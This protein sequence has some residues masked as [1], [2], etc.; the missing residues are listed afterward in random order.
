MWVFRPSS[1]TLVVC[2]IAVVTTVEWRRGTF[3]SGSFDP[4]VVIK[5][6][7]SLVGLAIA[8]STPRPPGPRTRLGT[9]SLWFLGLYLLCTVFGALTYGSLLAG[10][11]V[12]F[13]VAVLAATVFFLLRSVP[14]ERVLAGLVWA[15]GLLV[16]VAALLGFRTAAG[17]RLEG[18]VPP[19]H[20]NE[21]ALLSGLVVLVVA[22]RL[23]LGET[24]WLGG[25][26]VV[27]FLGLMW[28][29]G[30]RTGLIMLL[31][32]LAVM[33]LH[34]RRPAVGLVVGFFAAAAVGL[35]VVSR[36]SLVGSF[37]ARDGTGDSTLQSRFIA[38]SAARLWADSFW[39]GAFGG[40]L[41]IKE[42][43]VK[44][45]WWNK[46]VLDSSWASVLV[47]AGLV[48]SVIAIG[49]VLWAWRG[50]RLAEPPY[51]AL[52]L[53]TL[54]FLVGRGM[55]ESGLFDASPAFLFFM[56]VSLLAEGGSRQRLRAE[57]LERVAGPR[58]GDGA[59]R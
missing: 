31:V 51:R 3:F 47:Q 59:D 28:A 54:V 34:V 5:G 17:G 36:T 30:S 1:R 11:V 41:S 48:G 42:I 21:M 45:Q 56:T 9:G 14:A 8:V 49:W 2:L 29:T 12:A 7:L 27:V 57:A 32:G 24:A 25:A 16:V 50:A 39:Q 6:V 35:A 22:W 15:C 4:V 19:I 38:W 44:G 26:V 55:L 43:P 23:V 20:P 53:G 46:Q 52:F 33:V 58:E 13:R 37:L 18:G 40:G 10:G